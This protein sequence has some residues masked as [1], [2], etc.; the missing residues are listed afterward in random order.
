MLNCRSTSIDTGSSRHPGNPHG[1]AECEAYRARWNWSCDEVTAARNPPRLS[2]FA[3]RIAYK[4]T[5]FTR[6]EWESGERLVDELI[7]H[8]EVAKLLGVT[9]RTLRTWIKGGQVPGPIRIGRKQFWVKSVF[10]AW[11][12]GRAQSSCDQ[13]SRKAPDVPPARRGRPRLPA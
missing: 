13:P 8:N 10:D 9:T 11:L 4:P 1:T 7:D 12:K 2:R 3:W 5:R 6:D